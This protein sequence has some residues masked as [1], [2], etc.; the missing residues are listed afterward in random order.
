MRET[1]QIEDAK[2]AL[3]VQVRNGMPRNRKADQKHAKNEKRNHSKPVLKCEKKKRS[4]VGEKSAKKNNK[5]NRRDR[6]GLKD[7]KGTRCKIARKFLEHEK[8]NNWKKRGLKNKSS[9]EMH[10]KNEKKNVWR[11]PKL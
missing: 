6:T 5:R 2:I 8:S 3:P 10:L 1:R 7:E 9:D 11:M 4:K